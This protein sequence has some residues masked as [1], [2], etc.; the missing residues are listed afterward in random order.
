MSQFEEMYPS[1]ESYWRAVILF[2]ANAASYKFALAKALL[3]L[4]SKETVFIKLD[5]LALPFALNVVEHIKQVDK[6][7]QRPTGPFLDACRK[8]ARGEIDSSA[9]R[10]VS[11]RYGFINVIDAF[12]VVNGGALPV[13]FFKDER[14]P[15]QGLVIT[16]TLLTLKSSI[17]FSS[18]P[19]EVEA[20]WRL[21]ETAWELNI[22]KNLLRIDNDKSSDYLFTT[23]DG[24]RKAITSSRDA[25]NGY[26]KGK[27]FYCFADITIVIK[28][29]Y[30]ADV[31]HFF[32]W[33][34]S[35]D[36][37]LNQNWNGIWNLVLACTSCNRGPKGK[38]ALVPNLRYLERLER[39]NNFLISSHHPLRETLMSQT[40][41]TEKLRASF[42]QQRYNEAS[43]ALIH[44]WTAS[45]ENAPAF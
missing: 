6:Q 21:V 32:A 1:D 5:D 37:D 10:D 13:T 12:H 35:R 11:V 25:L 15:R 27:C 19:I 17:Q 7:G 29:D 45:F 30:L 41:A 42:L 23:F 39:R 28:S 20:R 34:L 9:L 33:A 16:D 31:D 4:A 44:H 43:N 40:G 18:L 22:S 26:Q 8:Y 24:R 36:Q 3:D 2:G 14:R 38:S